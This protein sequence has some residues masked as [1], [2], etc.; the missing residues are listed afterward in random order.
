MKRV[1]LDRDDDVDEENVELCS[2]QGDN[3]NADD[4]G[5][6][7][8]ADQQQM[9][10]YEEEGDDD[11]DDGDDSDI[12]KDER[13]KRILEHAVAKLSTRLDESN[14]L[15]PLK[16][17]ALITSQASPFLIMMACF[18]RLFESVQIT[19]DGEL[20]DETPAAQK[21][22][23]F[24]CMDGTR[25]CM[26]RWRLTRDCL[27]EGILMLPPNDV[28]IDVNLT[29]LVEM[30][31]GASK[32]EVMCIY[33]DNDVNPS[34]MIVESRE[35][36]R[37]DKD[38]IVLMT[39][40]PPS[41][42]ID[43]YHIVYSNCIT[44][45]STE[46]AKIVHRGKKGYDTISFELEP[47]SFNIRFCGMSKERKSVWPLSSHGHEVT[48][49]GNF[50]S[51]AKFNHALI[52]GVTHITKA[53]RFVKL[54]MPEPVERMTEAGTVTVT[55]TPLHLEY[56]VAAFGSVGFFISP[57]FE[58]IDNDMDGDEMASRSNA[59]N[60]DRLMLL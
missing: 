10:E 40:T 46:F 44:L 31:D 19:I 3:D 17:F 24:T 57:L 1:R 32:V 53:T 48:L 28:Y 15:V 7:D 59:T 38:S 20:S 16:R 51:P 6:S 39:P 34:K 22:V 25:T 9:T 42:R 43:R 35:K 26:A 4:D 55:T 13:A 36:S 49:G 12:D 41:E 5:D 54:S 27:V 45:D 52:Q 50:I 2:A 14:Q 21:G 47:S 11:D 58:D 18:A 56:P 8:G 29:D 37:V 30:L 23:T 33:L 60:R